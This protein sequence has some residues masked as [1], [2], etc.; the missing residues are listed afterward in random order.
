MT[1]NISTEVTVTNLSGPLK[2]MMKAAETSSRNMS[3][4]IHRKSDVGIRQS[5]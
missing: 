4:K 2:S 5:K 1:T 3:G